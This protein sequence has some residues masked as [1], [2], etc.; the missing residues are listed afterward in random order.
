MQQNDEAVF[1]SAHATVIAN[2][3]QQEYYKQHLA[4]V[5]MSDPDWKVPELEYMFKRAQKA[6]KCGRFH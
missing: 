2:K 3:T 6:C 5:K 1:V 4:E